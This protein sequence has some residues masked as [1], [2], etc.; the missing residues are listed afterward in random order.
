MSNLPTSFWWFACAWAY[1]FGACVGSFLNVVIYRLPA[2]LSL[3]HPGSRCPHCK[4]PIRATDNVPILGWLRLAGRCR[5]CRAAIS[6]R[7]PA[8]E[9]AVG[10]VFT[11]LAALEPLADGINLP[12]LRGGT[13][14]GWNGELLAAVYAYHLTLMCGLMCAALIEYDGHALPLRLFVP[15]VLVGVTVPFVWTEVRP[16]AS[17]WP[18]MLQSLDPGEP[19][20]RDAVAGTAIA[21]LLAFA[22]HPWATR[23]RDRRVDWRSMLAALIWIGLFLGWQATC[24]VAT[25]SASTRFA[26]VLAGR[27]RGKAPRIGLIGCLALWSFVWIVGW[28]PI[29]SRCPF[30]GEEANVWTLLVAAAV[31]AVLSA[32]T[33]KVVGNRTP[34]KPVALT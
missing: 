18:A 21:A 32:M 6:P 16:V 27:I 28:K 8:V 14:G 9:F 26:I 11:L 20:V 25:L 17:H 24:A 33:W 7:Y 13:L 15:L 34:A 22:A 30:V 19:A 1:V 5:A 4:T 3:L 31:T 12:P 10:A 23:K 29:V 2:G